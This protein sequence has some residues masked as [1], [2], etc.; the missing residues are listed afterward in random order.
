MA[1]NI[2]SIVSLS[3]RK[4]NFKMLMWLIQFL[5]QHGDAEQE[6]T[7]VLL[8][9][10]HGTSHISHIGKR[11][12]LC[13]PCWETWRWSG[14]Q[15]HFRTHLFIF[16]IMWLDY[17]SD[18]RNRQ[19]ITLKR[20]TLVPAFLSCYNWYTSKPTMCYE[21]LFIIKILWHMTYF[22]WTVRNH[23]KIRKKPRSLW[24]PTSGLVRNRL[25]HHKS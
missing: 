15:S 14:E 2:L 4:V 20:K 1:A 3:K 10:S 9:I 22:N 6:K 11:S 12:G 21:L 8:D 18:E 19:N 25:D 13:H 17:S 16:L 24:S 5:C 23:D 7:Q